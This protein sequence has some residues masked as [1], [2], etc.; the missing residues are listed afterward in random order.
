[1]RLLT[2]LTALIA[3]PTLAFDNYITRTGSELYDGNTPFRFASLNAPELHRIEDDALGVCKNDSRSWGQYFK[4]P[5]SDEQ[6]NWVQSFVKS[7]LNVTR[8][9]VFS[10]AQKDDEK[11]ARETHILPPEEKDGMPRLNEKAM[12][13]FDQL[14]A[15]SDN[16]GLR[17]IIPF[18]DHWEWWGG[19]KQLAAFYAETEDDFYNTN[20]KTYAAYKSIIKQVITRKN[21][22]TGRYY[23][24]EKSIMAWETGNELVKSTTD[25]VSQTAAYIKSLAPNQLVIDGNYLSILDSSLDDP[26]ID[27]ISNHFYTVNGNNKPQTVKNDLKK[28]AGKKPYIV[29]E[30]GLQPIEGLQ[31]IMET[32]VNYSYNGVKASGAMIWGF[33]GRRHNG[34]FYWHAEGDSG[35]YSYHLPGFDAG[36]ANEEKKVIQLVRESQ[37]KMNGLES[38]PTLP[39]PQAPILRNVTKD[40]KLSWLG[41]PVGEHYSIERK[42]SNSADWERVASEV[43][44]GKNKFNPQKDTLFQDTWP[45]G[46]SGEISYRVIAENEAGK[47]A[48]SNVVNT[49]SNNKN[50]FIKVE[51][52]QFIKNGKP[53]Y[54]VGTNYWYGP[55]LAAPDG[56]RKRLIKELDNLANNGIKN[57]RILAGADGGITDS[58]VKPALQIK[59]NE[60]NENLLI[61]LDYLLAEMS[62]RGMEAVLYLNNN[63]IWSG[64]MSQ[65]LQWMGY[66]DVPNPF[67]EGVS[68]Q[69]YMDYTEQFYSCDPCKASYYKHVKFLLERTNSITGVPYKNDPT[70]MSWQ[71]ANEPRVFSE[72]SK[73]PFRQWVNESVNLINVLAPNQLISTGNE[74]AAGSMG[75]LELFRENHTNKHIDYLTM[76]MWPKN[77]SWYDVNNEAESLET[78]IDEANQYMSE[79]IEIAKSM[80]KPIVM[81]EFGFPRNKESNSPKSLTDYR[82]KFYKA[83]FRNIT[84]S[85]NHDGE[86]AGFNFWAYAGYGVANPKSNYI[87]QEGDDYLGD[88]AQEPQGLN[89]VFATDVST[90]KIIKKVN[91]NLQGVNQ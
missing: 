76:H 60:Y 5:T 72:K 85:R 31:D 47:S 65:Y 25:F 75:S 24:E 55:L 22:I 41:S 73:I 89:S 77:W 91:E 46:Y 26:N 21:T 51:G 28:I 54:Y 59:P 18:I 86:L 82:D 15:H 40:L 11:C 2:L 43:T 48:P 14:I 38:A 57:L 64:G 16:E 50:T 68:W 79:H 67:E 13:I 1:M 35:Y 10:V 62:K 34:G 42:L 56:D 88:P 71:L 4:W 84:H 37:A 83:M 27:I 7:G 23:Y 66:G 32:V 20:S 49:N 81:S 63:W 52:S 12:R 44:D 58:S 45:A 74:G 33:R 87:W 80:N 9:Y 70:I 30:F 53:Y 78:A 19:R 6:K 90:L 61:G 69:E 36:N 39:V 29:G 17:L 3:T 8:T